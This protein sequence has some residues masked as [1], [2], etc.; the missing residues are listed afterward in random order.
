LPAAQFTQ[1]L[2][3]VAEYLPAVQSTQT[4]AV[5]A[6]VA[7]EYLPAPQSAQASEIVVLRVSTAARIDA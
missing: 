7:A 3:D 6:P 4:L 2:S 1:V 5:V